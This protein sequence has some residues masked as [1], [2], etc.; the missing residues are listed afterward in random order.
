V[1]GNAVMDEKQLL[2][3]NEKVEKLRNKI[4]EGM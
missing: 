2:L 3:V 4:V 1:T